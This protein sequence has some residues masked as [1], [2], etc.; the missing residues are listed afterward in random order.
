M[1]ASTVGVLHPGEMGSAL[2][3]A[4]RAGGHNVLWAS[5]DRSDATAGRARDAELEDAGSA[6]EVA[7]RSEVIFSV[8]PPHAAAAVARSIAGFEGIFV[9]A[10]AIAP[11]TAKTIA[12]EHARV[13]DGGIIGPPPRTA[14]TTPSDCSVRTSI[15]C[16][17][18]SWGLPS[19]SASC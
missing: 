8:C 5:A 4:L 7:R 17:T 10:N 6:G 9:D 11:A 12:A 1:T 16:S 13:V 18:S 2:A 14:G 15:R 3:E 19:A